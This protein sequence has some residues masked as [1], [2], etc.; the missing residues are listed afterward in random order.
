MYLT[1]YKNRKEETTAEETAVKEYF[2]FQDAHE[3]EDVVEEEESKRAHDDDES[4]SC[5]SLASI[6]QNFSIDEKSKEWTSSLSSSDTHYYK[7]DANHQ[8][9]S[10]FC[11]LQRSRE[12]RRQ[13]LRQRLS[14]QDSTESCC[15]NSNHHQQQQHHHQQQYEQDSFGFTGEYLNQHQEKEIVGEEE[16]KEQPQ[17]Q[18]QPQPEI[19]QTQ[20]HYE[21]NDQFTKMR[22]QTPGSDSDNDEED[23][24]QEESFAEEE[25][26]RNSSGNSSNS[27]STKT[28]D[29]HNLF[30]DE[31]D[32]GEFHYDNLRKM[33]VILHRGK[34]ATSRPGNIFYRKLVFSLTDKYEATSTNK[35]EKTGLT[36]DVYRM[37]KN[38]GGRFLTK[39]S[40]GMYQV[41]QMGKVRRKIAQAFRDAKAKK[42]YDEKRK[43]NNRCVI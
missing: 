17:P 30:K 29:R 11:N 31:N 7:P 10:Y 24:E 9:L 32:S 27:S 40:K 20:T 39:N 2:R 34:V 15:W 41:E 3:K 23:N 21:M 43:R 36:W 35:K 16:E 37:I 6:L 38:E 13:I 19:Q 33:D 22:I 4:I 8:A 26:S 28:I 25:E 18:P 5:S 14:T 12:I 42:K 1:Y